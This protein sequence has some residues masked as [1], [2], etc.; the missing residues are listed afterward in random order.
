MSSREIVLWLD[1]RWYDALERH[2][3]D[4]TL[5]EKLDSYLDELCNNLIPDNEYE[6]ISKEIDEEHREWEAQRE[7][8][9][10]FA[11]F[12][13]MEQNEQSLFLVDEPLDFLSVA[14]SLRRYLRVEDAAKSFHHYYAAA[15]KIGAGE[16]VRYTNERR[17]N[18]RRVCGAFEIDLDRGEF[19]SLDAK[20]G[21]KLY[22]VKDVCAAA[23]HAVRKNYATTEEQAYRFATHINGKEISTAFEPQGMAMS[24]MM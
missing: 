6:Q 20:D 19:A 16:F 11:V 18:T 14:C 1:D 8:S 10:R 9:R 2:I 15:Q 17:E 23:Y 12:K 3:K 5:R 13:V 4:E 22:K 21:W 7:A 24:P